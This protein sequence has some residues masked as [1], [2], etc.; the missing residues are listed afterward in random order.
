VPVVGENRLLRKGTKS[1]GVPRQY[2]G[3]AGWVENAGRALTIRATGQGTGCLANA[4]L[5]GMRR[6]GGLMPLSRSG[7]SV[8]THP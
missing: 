7:N 1:A 4:G 6:K 2:S 8:E 3:A 5:A